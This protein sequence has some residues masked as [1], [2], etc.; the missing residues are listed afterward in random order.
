MRPLPLRVAAV[1]PAAGTSERM[2]RPKLILPLAGGT[3]LGR[4][5]AALR[6]GGADPIVVVVPPL[7]APGADLLIAEADRQ[8]ATAVI[9]PA[10]PPDMRASIQLGLDRLAA[11][12]PPDGL[13]LTPGDSPGLSAERVAQVIGRFREEPSR[14]II[15]AHGGRRGHPLVLPW[16]LTA[17][18]RAL[19]PEVGVNALLADHP[20]R[21]TLLEG[22][23]PGV[24]SDLDTPEDYRRWAT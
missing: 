4:V 16:D 8:G 10:Q 17:A 2:G 3:V 13:L 11:G 22:D 20:D 12:P 9:P 21:I 19:P 24:L 6:G 1:V 7:G 14:I 18:I 15:A 23:D 5:L